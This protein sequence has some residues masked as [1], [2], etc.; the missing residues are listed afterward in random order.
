MSEIPIAHRDAMLTNPFGFTHNV[1]EGDL[2][3]D[4]CGARVINTVQWVERHA[5]WHQRHNEPLI[6]G[7]QTIEG[8]KA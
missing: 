5:L 1:R 8:E 4:R 2:S 6:Q 7:S 3:C